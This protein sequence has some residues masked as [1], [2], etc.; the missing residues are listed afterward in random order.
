ME[1][2]QYCPNYSVKWIPQLLW[3]CEDSPSRE[4]NFCKNILVTVATIVL[5]HG[6]QLYSMRIHTNSH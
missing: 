5:Q 4:K 3:D 2:L 1:R 6:L